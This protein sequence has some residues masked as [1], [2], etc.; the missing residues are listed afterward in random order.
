MTVT[1]VYTN[2]SYIKESEFNLNENESKLL[3]DCMVLCNDATYS[4]KKIKL[5]TLLK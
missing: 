3:V 2:D 4:E 1:T 5:A